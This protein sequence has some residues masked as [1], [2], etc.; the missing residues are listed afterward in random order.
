MVALGAAPIVAEGIQEGLVLE[1][2]ELMPDNGS[3][4]VPGAADAARAGPVRKGVW[5]CAN[6]KNMIKPASYRSYLCGPY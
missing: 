3:T 5:F 2:V 4:I 6:V 1:I